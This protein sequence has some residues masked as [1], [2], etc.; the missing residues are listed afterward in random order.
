MEAGSGG[1]TGRGI[2]G[3]EPTTASAPISVMGEEAGGIGGIV[4]AG[5]AGIV[6]GIVNGIVGGTVGGTVG[7]IVSGGGAGGGGR[8]ATFNLNPP[9]GAGGMVAEEELS[10]DDAG[11]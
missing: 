2:K 6:G 4:A 8:L 5:S 9:P 1:K 10:W 7:G 3:E 11:G